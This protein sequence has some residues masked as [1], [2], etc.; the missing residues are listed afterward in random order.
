MHL[1]THS[2][3]D[4]ANYADTVFSTLTFKP[5]IPTWFCSAPPM[6]GSGMVPQGISTFLASRFHGSLIFGRAATRPCAT[7]CDTSSPMQSLTRTAACSG[8]RSSP[9]HSARHITGILNGNTI[10]ST[11][12]ANM[13]PRHLPRISPRRSC[14]TSATG[15]DSPNGTLQGPSRANGNSS[16]CCLKPFRAAYADGDFEPP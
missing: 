2:R 9:I 14:S 3:L 13:L 6:A 12:S 7:S 11:T 8:R 15:E 10:P 5:S 16:A 4:Q 1:V